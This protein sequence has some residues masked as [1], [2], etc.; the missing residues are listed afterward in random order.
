[1]WVVGKLLGDV[2]AFLGVALAVLELDF[3]GGA[4]ELARLVE[5]VQRHL[6][7]ILEHGAVLR[8]VAGQRQL[9]ADGDLAL[10]AGDRGHGAQRQRDQCGYE[11]AKHAVSP[12]L[13]NAKR[14]RKISGGAGQPLRRT[15]RKQQPS[16]PTFQVSDSSAKPAC[17]NVPLST[18][19]AMRHRVSI[20]L[21]DNWAS[22]QA[23]LSGQACSLISSPS[24]SQRTTSGSNSL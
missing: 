5:L 7:R 10:R 16:P 4:L 19:P 14:V 24:W 3:D 13:V 20:R 11:L 15:C 8:V 23:S 2:D 12:L 18:K 21:G 22:S 6:G 17:S 1:G 9:V